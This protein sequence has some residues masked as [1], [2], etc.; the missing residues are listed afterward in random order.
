M[1]VLVTVSARRNLSAAHYTVA[2]KSVQHKHLN[3]YEWLGSSQP[4]GHKACR[5]TQNHHAVRQS[6]RNLCA[7]ECLRVYAPMRAQNHMQAHLGI[8]GML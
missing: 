3:A 7:R 5:L 4:T 8:C 1:L 6:L 2:P